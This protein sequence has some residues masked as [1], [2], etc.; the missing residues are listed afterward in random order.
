MFGRD[1]TEQAEA[2]REAIPVIV[3]KCIAAVD[4]VGMEYEGLT[5]LSFTDIRA[6]CFADFDIL[7]RLQ[8]STGRREG[9]LV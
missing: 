8:V 3:R 9:L 2:D 7:L 5:L 4:A 1:L 6:R